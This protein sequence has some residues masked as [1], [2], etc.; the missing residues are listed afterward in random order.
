MLQAFRRANERNPLL[1][2]HCLDEVTGLMEQRVSG[3]RWDS[4]PVFF[5]Q[6]QFIIILNTTVDDKPAY[7]TIY[8]YIYMVWGLL[9]ACHAC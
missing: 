4:D 6:R 8:I 3:K 7:R 9:S 1:K 2:I 5:S